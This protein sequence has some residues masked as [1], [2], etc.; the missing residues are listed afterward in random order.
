MHSPPV[1]AAPPH[2]TSLSSGASSAGFPY[3]P[4]MVP[5]GDWTAVSICVS[6]RFVR[7]LS[8]EPEKGTRVPKKRSSTEMRVPLDETVVDSLPYGVV[9]V[10]ADHTITSSNATA[11]RF[12]PQLEEADL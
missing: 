6:Q 7:S 5:R 9:V 1:S 8:V 4:C 12:L 10:Q 2:P 3:L 11:R